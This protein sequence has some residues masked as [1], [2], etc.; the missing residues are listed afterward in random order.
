MCRIDWTPGY[1]K[2]SG[3]ANQDIEVDPVTGGRDA[4]CMLCK[5]CCVTV[6]IELPSDLRRVLSAARDAVNA[7]I[8]A[9]VEVHNQFAD[10]YGLVTPDGP[11]ADFVDLRFCCTRCSTLFALTADTY[12]GS[13]GC[14]TVLTM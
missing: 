11:W 7:G 5:D 2:R 13:C 9:P 1:L 4:G 6:R 14:W 3:I 12:H 10:P 8:L